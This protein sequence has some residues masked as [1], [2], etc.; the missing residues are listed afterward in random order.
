MLKAKRMSESETFND[1]TLNVLEATD[2]IIQ[3]NIFGRI[4]PGLSAL[5]GPGF[6]YAGLLYL[7]FCRKTLRFCIPPC[8]KN[9]TLV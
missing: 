5:E 9:Q 3:K 6:L 2:G 7:K 8:I 4:N 1:G